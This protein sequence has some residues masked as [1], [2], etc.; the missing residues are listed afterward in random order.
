MVFE[1]Y[2]EVTNVLWTRECIR[3][4]TEDQRIDTAA[5]EEENL[6]DIVSFLFRSA[7]FSVS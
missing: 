3:C 2:A 7:R 1:N 6:F 5:S 4:D